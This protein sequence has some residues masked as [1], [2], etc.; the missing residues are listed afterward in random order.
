MN[1]R[2][3]VDLIVWEKSHYLTLCIYEITRSFPNHE[4]FGIVSQLRRSSVSIGA[5]ICEGYK[6]SNRE[7]VRYL[8]IS[9]GSLEETKYYLLLSKDLKYINENQYAQ[10]LSLTQEIGRM[11][12]SFIKRISV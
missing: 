6:R 5:N 4:S 9:V 11:I 12:T 3:F 1:D 7:F 10:L 8:N 2:S